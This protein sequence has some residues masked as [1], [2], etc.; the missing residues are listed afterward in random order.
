MDPLDRGFTL[1]DG[2]FETVLWADG[3][4]RRL[5]RHLARL[6]A[7]CEALGLPAP[8]LATAEALMQQAV[9]DAELGDRRAAVRLTLTAGVGGRGL[10]R[11]EAI[12]P[13][14]VATAAPAPP[15]G[16]SARLITAITRRNEGSIASRWKTLAYMDNVLARREARAA[17][18]DEAL[19]L[20]NAG[21]I[22][23]ASAANLFW[24]E[25]DGRL[26]T[27]ALECGAL[28]GIT[29]EA[30]LAL[31]WEVA[32][33]RAPNSVLSTARHVFLTNSL[34]GLRTVAELDGRALAP[35]PELERLKAA[36]T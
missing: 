16:G 35:W 21:E 1:G 8:D 5:D 30:V 32:E 31:D 18:A 3:T 23:C 26:C 11:P 36:L 29:R 10:D 12:S 24:V 4:L 17:G 20:N 6:T 28:A 27:P 19:M 9:A 15:A 14:M 33:V 25:D 7:G 34:I 13:E 22:A 2:L